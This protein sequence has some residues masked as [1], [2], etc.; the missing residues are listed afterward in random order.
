MGIAL[1]QL[2]PASEDRASGAQVI[3]G[4]LKFNNSSFIITRTPG[5]AG[6][7]KTWTWSGWIKRDSISVYQHALIGGSN[8]TGHGVIVRFSPAS[9]GTDTLQIGEYVSGWNWE[10]ITDRV[11]RDT[12]WYHIVFDVDTTQTTTADRVKLYVNGVQETSFGTSSYPSLNYDTIYNTNTLQVLGGQTWNGSINGYYNGRMSNVY[13][14]DG[15]ALDASYFGFTDGLTNTW[16]PKKFDIGAENNSNNGTTWD[17]TNTTAYDGGVQTDTVSGTSKF[18]GVN[19][20]FTSTLSSSVI[21]RKSLRLQMYASIASFD[22]YCDIQVN[23]SG[24]QTVTVHESQGAQAGIYDLN[25]TGTLSSIKVTA[26]GGANVGLAQV[27]VDDYVLI[28]GAGD[29]KFYL[30]IDG[31]SPIGEDKSG[32][33]TINDGRTWSGT[34]TISSGGAASNK[35]LSK[36]FDG[37]VATAF[38]GDT[39][40]ATVTVP[41]SATISAGGVRVYAAVTSGNPLVVLLKNGDTTVE[42]INGANSGGQWYASS[43]YAGAITSLVISRTGRAPEFN[44]I[45]IGGIVLIDNVAGNSWTPVNFGG[46][47]ALDNPIVSGALP[48]LNTDGGGNVAG[49]GVRTDAYHANLALAVPFV[50]S[51]I[52]VSNSVNSGSTT[53]ADTNNGSTATNSLSNFYN[54]SHDFDGSNDTCSF[55]SVPACG[56]GDWTVE[57]W[58]YSESSAL[59]TVYRRIV[60]TGTNANAAIQIGHIGGSSASGGYITYTRADNS[61]YAV[62]TSKVTDRWAHIAVVR[63]SG[64]VNVYTDGIKGTIADSDAYDKTGTTW[65]V[66]GYG[67]STSSGRF[68]GKIQDLRVYPGV[69]KYTSNFVVPATNSDI[70]PDTPSG[71]SG[72]SKLAKVTDGAVAFDGADG[73]ALSL[74]NNSDIQ[75]GSGTNWTIEFFAYRTGAFVDYDVIAGKGASSTYEWFIEGFADGSVDILYSANGSTTWTGQHEIMSNMALNRWYHIALVRNG[76]GANNFKAYVDGK[77]TLQTTAFDIYAGSGVLHIGGYNGA[78]AQDPPITISNFRI[79]NGS[80]VYTS[81]FTPPTRELTNVTNTKLLCCQSNIYAPSAAV[82]PTITTAST[83]NLPCD[84]DT[85]TDQSASSVSITDNS[86]SVASAGTNNLGITTAAVIPGGTSA[87]IDTRG[88]NFNRTGL[89]TFDSYF[90]YNGAQAGRLITNYNPGNTG[91]QGGGDGQGIAMLTNGSIVIN[92]YG[93]SEI[94][95]AGTVESN[96]WYHLRFIANNAAVLAL[97]LNGVK[98][99]SPA[100]VIDNFAHNGPIQYGAGDGVT[101]SGKL[102]P[103]RFTPGVNLGAPPIGGL[104]TNSSDISNNSVHTI[105]DAGNTTAT[106]FNPFTTDI[107]AVRGQETGYATWN[108]LNNNGG[109]LSNG[110]LSLAHSGAA[111][112]SATLQIPTTGKWYWEYFLDRQVGGG[113]LGIGDGSAMRGTALG[114]WTKLYGY[115]PN[116]QKYEVLTGAGYGATLAA[117]DLVGVKYDADTRQLEFLKNNISQGV[118]YTNVSSDYDYY[119]SIHVN[120]SDVTANFGQK[121]FK[122]APPDGFQPL[123]AANVK[124]VKVITRPD[125][126]VSAVLWT[127]NS[128]A[129]KIVT[130]NAPDFVWTKL[131]NTDNNHN[132]FDSVRGVEKK[133]RSSTDGPEGTES[134]SV[135][136]FNSDGFSIG[137]TGNVN[138]SYNYVA[139]CWRAGG[140]KNTFNVDDVGYAS[141]AAA[142]LTGGTITPTGSSVGTR[143]GFSIIGF[144]DGGSA[145]SI[146]H[147]LTK[148]PDFYIVKFRGATGNWSIYHKSLGNT[149]RLKFTTDNSGSADAG[150]WQNTSPTSSLFYLGGNLITSTTQIAYLWHDVPGLQ[151]F[152]SYIGNGEDDGTF[153]ETGFR[154]TLLWIKN[155]TTDGEL[156]CAHDSKR[157]PFNP[158]KERLALNS[159][160][161]E[162]DSQDARIKDF[163]SNGF[164]IRGQSGEQNTDGDVY[165]YAAWAEAPTFNLYGGQSNAR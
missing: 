93:D 62:N 97:Y 136:A 42:T 109:T 110:N 78:T 137:T 124:P 83:L 160:G 66:S 100:T 131:R 151:K 29:N 114:D 27:I 73:T 99:A 75:L 157:D 154:P 86:I 44:G 138:G 59:D 163:L 61:V 79:V 126:Y 140:S 155:I 123:N 146:P 33:V 43:S 142:G 20:N 6:N 101:F 23:G 67:G 45:E 18:T 106:N 96:K 117:G 112:V 139:W 69:A 65:Y 115:S 88:T 51:T 113:V 58:V 60:S 24:E 104:V 64:S 39:S 10:L 82:I 16:R 30:P 37:S 80:S 103:I 63:E 141:A 159:S 81:N 116:G 162:N 121:P 36:G 134:G 153:V 53:K 9:A 122:Y 31:N 54:G 120:D 26:K 133:L 41:V 25:F 165:I 38:E 15:Q 68:N 125:Q 70:L 3:D 32:I 71:V 148:A 92:D 164:K 108:S 128:T 98:I 147:G 28:N 57:F 11:F 4:S 105:F 149:K 150:W 94:A 49:V 161:E 50:G 55:A 127:G 85:F 35:E 13:L 91:N 74:D 119:P 130:N 14:I 5:S 132:L 129:R 135:T 76:S 46:S 144:T 152:G 22:T 107:N 40:G 77:Q 156:W 1:P 56:S 72:G 7:R 2:A 143:Q 34:A 12:G 8:S 48:I 145:C 95:A 52:D 19:G 87:A 17:S 158:A 21:V 89:Y 47:V 90:N 84:E 102:G 118:A 111:N